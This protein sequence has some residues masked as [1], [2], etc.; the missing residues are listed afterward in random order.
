VAAYRRRREQLQEAVTGRLDLIFENYA[1]NYWFKEMIGQSDS[2]LAH[3]QNLFVRL[4]V[5]RFLLF[6]HPGLNDLAASPAPPLSTTALQ[7]RFD[8]VAIEVFYRFSRGIE[9]SSTLLPL[10][11][12]A[13]AEQNMQSFA[14]LVL[15]LKV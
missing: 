3:T 5:L 11:V 7:A 14:H 8:P 4:A 2:L 15:L 10:V 13:L 1:R 9:H 6:S 12:K